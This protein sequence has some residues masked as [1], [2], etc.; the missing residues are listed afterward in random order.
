MA[1]ETGTATGVLDL[2]DKLLAFAVANGWT[3]DDPRSGGKM[4]F[5]RDNIFIAFSYD[6]TTANAV[7][8]Y[9]AL[10]FAAAT[11]PGAQANDSGNGFFNA[12]FPYSN[13]NIITSRH[14]ALGTVAFPSYHFF[15]SDTGPYLRVV[16]EVSAGSFRHFGFGKKISFG[17]GITGGEYCYGQVTQGANAS[18][19]NTNT[20]ALLDG[21][22][23]T[24]GMGVA[25]AG[26]VHLES[27]PDAPHASTKWGVTWADWPAA[28][29]NDR[30]ATPRE[31]AFVHGG[32]RGGPDARSLGGFSAGSQS[33]LIPGYPIQLWYRPKSGGAA[34][35]DLYR[36]GYLNDIRGTN[37]RFMSPGETIA[38]GGDDWLFFPTVAK[39][40]TAAVAGATAAQGIMYRKVTA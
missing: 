33:G 17:D 40:L 5:H 3:Q 16:V 20:C 37:I 2:L 4:A 27:L 28:Q 39:D 1:Y 13:A 24:A 6:T 34:Q 29:G 21:L 32:F 8:L 15:D 26:T 36:L 10:A 11:N 23:T 25:F 7:G 22:H 18:A 12:S 30:Q 31:R 14:V 35:A 9:Q 19:L 38:I